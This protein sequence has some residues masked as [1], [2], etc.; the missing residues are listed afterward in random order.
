MKKLMLITVA[1][2]VGIQAKAQLSINPEAGLNIANASYK[3]NGD[4]QSTSSILSY[5]AGVVL[6]IDIAKG[7]YIQPG[8][9]YSV[10][11]A[12]INYNSSILSGHIKST[13]DYLEIPLNLAYRYDLGNAGA[14]FAAVG[15]YMG[16]G[17][18][19]KNK[20]SVTTPLGSTEKE[21][22]IK[23]GDA[24]DEVKKIDYG[25]NFGIGYISPVGLYLRAQYGLGLA[26][27]ANASSVSSKNRVFGISLGYA[28]M[29]NER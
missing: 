12:E 28:F 26:N 9:F 14:V 11:G 23:F 4:K 7:F 21:D 13:L 8:I 29:L 6:D 18:K 1:T 19:G 2:I 25:V 27:L 5:K 17:M 3:I 15:P 10:K 16:L 20:T 22:D 24:D